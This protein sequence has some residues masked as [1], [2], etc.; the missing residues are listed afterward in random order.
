[1]TAFTACVVAGATVGMAA[2]R[3]D[4][5]GDY[6]AANAETVCTA[7]DL[8]PTV[9]GVEVAVINIMRDGL[10]PEDSGAALAMAVIGWCPDHEPEVQAFVDKWADA[11]SK[12]V[13]A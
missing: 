7:L 1:M 4:T 9:S 5:A 13:G 3:A 11:K 6:A 10:T 2:A 8:D 12:G